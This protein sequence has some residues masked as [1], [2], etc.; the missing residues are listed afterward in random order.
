MHYNRKPFRKSLS[1]IFMIA[2]IVSVAGTSSCY[3]TTIPPRAVNGVMDLRPWDFE[4]MKPVKLDGEWEFHWEKILGPESFRYGMPTH[5]AEYLTVPGVWNNRRTGDRIIHGDGYATFRLIILT[6]A[7]TGIRTLKMPVMATS[8]RIFANGRP[9]ASNGIV[10][11]HPDYAKPGYNPTTASFA[12]TGTTLELVLHIANFSSDK[13]G[14]W[15]SI[16]L[17]TE[18]EITKLRDNRLLYEYILLGGLLVMGLYHLGLFLLRRNERS[19]FYFGA[20]CFIIALRLTL[21]GEFILIR[22]FP[23]I[24]WELEMK[25]EFLTIYVGLPVFAMFIRSL[26]PAEM[27]NIA[28]QLYL[29]TGLF[30]S[31]PV[32]LLPL[33]VYSHLLAPF[34]IVSLLAFAHLIFTVCRAAVRKRTDAILVLIG[35]II[36]MGTAVNDILDT[37]LIIRTG[38]LL[39]SGLFIFVLLQSFILSRRSSGAFAD[40]VKLADIRQELEIA[41]RIQKSILP[42]SPP[43][44]KGMNMHIFTLPP[45]GISGDYYDWHIL[46]EQRIG[47]LSA[48]IVGHGV[49]AAMIASTV[50]IVF[51]LVRDRADSPALLLQAMN[52]MLVE[53]NVSQFITAS[54]SCI[55]LAAGNIVYANAGHP[56]FLIMPYDASDPIVADAAGRAMGWTND[57]RC[58]QNTLS[59]RP[60]D[61]LVI[62]T[63]GII[64]CRNARGELFGEKRFASCIKEWRNLPAGEFAK[65]LGARLTAWRK[66][67]GDF[68]DDI[69]VLIV[70]LNEGQLGARRPPR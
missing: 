53:R 6:N 55:N 30:F 65:R 34:H 39:P 5:G 59:L 7:A 40:A 41:R 22:F 44:M 1:A 36:L 62:H 4:R 3:E 21:T 15:N 20:F 58:E 10:S 45:E 31:L 9:L 18:S 37:N 23:G 54:Y 49:P 33:R 52:D 50:K 11:A 60:G 26:F 43:F 42:A 32:L 19:A 17:G 61:R 25:V 38:Y 69:T 51:S 66:P 70:D 29:I 14:P 57:I 8:Y 13:G 63:D 47:I 56:P 64:E 68:E 24:D 2:A 46:D 12:M 67:A 28:R 27:P 48:D 16:Y 35:L